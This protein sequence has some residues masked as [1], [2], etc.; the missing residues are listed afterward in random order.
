MRHCAHRCTFAQLLLYRAAMFRPCDFAK[1]DIVG[2]RRLRRGHL[3]DGAAALK[4]VV[5]LICA[6]CGCHGPTYTVHSLPLD[7][8]APALP[9][10]TELNLERMGGWAVG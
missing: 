6:L 10:S 1:N 9:P 5:V 2:C 7:F 4:F 3:V 8:Q